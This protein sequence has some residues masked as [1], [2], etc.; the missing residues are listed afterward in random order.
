M[1]RIRV[2]GL[3]LAASLLVA[4]LAAASASALPQLGRCEAVP[5][6]AGMYE[7]ATCTGGAKA[8][9][10]FEWTPGAVKN[11]FVTA[12]GETIFEPLTK[13]QIKCGSIL[14][15]G[16][17]SSIDEHLTIKLFG[18]EITAFGGKCQNAGPEEIVS[19]SIEGDYGF[20]KSG[21][22]PAVGIDLTLG[23]FPLP[24]EGPIEFNC[25]TPSHGL[26]HVVIGGEVIA[27]IMPLDKMLVTFKKKYTE[28]NGKPSPSHFEGGPVESLKITVGAN[29]PAPGGVLT[30]KA[31]TQSN[32]EKLEIKALP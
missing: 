13:E 22:T 5:P 17:Y 6:G 29:P 1:S 8:G 9:G 27:R 3:S 31:I 14:E 21:A 4:A 24:E 20:I 2:V 30:V 18:C 26:I 23:E 10:S 25:D 15:Q 28:K 7:V 16:E 12:G 32:E 11:K 19:K